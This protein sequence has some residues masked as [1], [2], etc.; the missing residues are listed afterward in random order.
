MRVKVSTLVVFG[1]VVATGVATA[2]FFMSRSSPGTA[3]AH[4]TDSASGSARAR[5]SRS[6]PRFDT[7]TVETKQSPPSFVQP[8]PP[9]FTTPPKTEQELLKERASKDGYLFREDGS[10]KVFVVQGGTKYFVP[11]EQEFEALG[12]KWDQIEVVPRGSLS[13][14]RDRPAERVLLR[15][16]DSAAVY[17]YENGQ[18]RGIVSPQAFERRGYKWS[19]IKVVPSGTLKD[20]TLGASM[21]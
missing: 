14:L 16:R 7:S 3:V 20:E 21:Q 5:R 13:F 1:A 9:E 4:S 12:Y 2:L 8:P 17:Y 15:E 11:S 6:L 18:K 10:N 19:D